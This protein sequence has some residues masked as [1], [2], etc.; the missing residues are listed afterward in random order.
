MKIEFLTD[1]ELYDFHKSLGKIIQELDPD[2][3][4][5]VIGFANS[6]IN[7]GN[8]YLNQANSKL[9]AN[10]YT[11]EELTKLKKNIKKPEMED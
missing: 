2:N 1:E 6:L 3:P 10:A 11:L 5:E 9:I 8:H 7:M 4:F